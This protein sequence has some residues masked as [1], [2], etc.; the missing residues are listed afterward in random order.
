MPFFETEDVQDLFSQHNLADTIQ[1]HL[2]R[3]K[4]I[5][6]GIDAN[7]LLITPTEDHVQMVVT[8][9][10]IAMPTLLE[11]QEYID[12]PDE[13]SRQIEDYGRNVNVKGFR[14]QLVIP[15]EGDSGFFYRYAHGVSSMPT[16]AKVF[17]KK[18]FIRVEGYDLA[19]DQI[20]ERIDKIKAEV[21]DQLV[22]Q[23]S[24]IS[25]FMQRMESGA[26]Q[27][28]ES[29]K[30]RILESRSI[31]ASIGYPMR[32]RPNDPMTY[33]A[34]VPRKLSP[35]KSVAPTKPGELFAPEPVLDEQEYQHILKVLQDMTLVME[36]SPKAFHRL[37]EE[38]LRDFYLVALNSHYEG[39][40]TGET[41]NNQGKTDILIRKDNKNIFIAECKFW[42]GPVSFTEA[43]NQL[44]GYLSWRDTKAALIIFSRNQSFSPVLE[45]IRLAAATHPH[46]KSGPIV[47]GDT[48]FRYVFGNPTDH[49]REI[50]LTVLAFNV[51]MPG[52]T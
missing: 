46:K 24:M 11:D 4:E 26:R 32:R 27:E 1:L 2:Q 16:R 12:D 15:F 28:I 44:L 22:R 6:D 35:A 7:Q 10:Q 18:L 31:A 37:E 23:T 45:S 48:Q 30:K 41:F 8:H 34:S 25:D 21:K 14:Y 52:L 19:Q 36:R 29:R 51:P 43:V 13:I 47:K 17:L 5:V 40:A 50:I 39:D 3:V 33:I 49:N 42:H 9:C 20:R 38:H